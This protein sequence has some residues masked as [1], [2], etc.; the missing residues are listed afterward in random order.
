M[1]RCT[2][3][4][5]ASCVLLHNFL[6]RYFAEIEVAVTQLPAYAESY[7][8]EILTSER[9]TFAYVCAFKAVAC[10]KLTKQ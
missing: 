7:V 4:W 2:N 6:E 8:E 5:R 9:A 1:L 10:W 3:N